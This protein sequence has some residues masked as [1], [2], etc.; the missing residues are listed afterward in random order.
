MKIKDGF[1][2]RKVASQYVV[3]PCNNDINFNGMISL[4]ES[5]AFLFNLLKENITKD[6]LLQAMLNEYDVSKEVALNDIEKFIKVLQDNNLLD[7]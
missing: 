7:L 6:D 3:M 1:L 5:G 4:N 2:I